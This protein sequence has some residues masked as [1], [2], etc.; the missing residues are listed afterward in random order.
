MDVIRSWRFVEH[1]LLDR[2]AV[3]QRIFLAEHLRTLL[4]E[5]A[6]RVGANP[7][8][9]TRFEEATCQPG[10]PHD[11]HLHV[12]WFCSVEDLGAGC[13]D[14]PPLYPWRKETLAAAGIEPTL[15]ARNNSIDPAP[16]T[17]NED[18]ER[19]VKRQKPHKDVF[20]FLARRKAWEKQPHPG[21]TYCK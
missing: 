5:H 4:L 21:R 12:R 13:E 3:V 14:L 2:A 16:L 1:M 19:E 6:R 10:Y 7:E 8:A 20:A 17:T 15:A 18:V 11:D 9:I